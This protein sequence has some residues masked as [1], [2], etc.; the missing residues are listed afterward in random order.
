MICIAIDMAVTILLGEGDTLLIKLQKN[1]LNI[2]LL[3]ITLLNITLLS[4]TLLNITL[5]NITLLN[6]TLLNI[7]LIWPVA[8]IAN[9]GLE[10][11]YLGTLIRRLNA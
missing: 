4:I 9:A 8:F 2:T 1:L 10:L 6:I 5:M 3:S 11:M 7:T